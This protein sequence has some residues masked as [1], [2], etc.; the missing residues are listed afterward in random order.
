[1][2]SAYYDAPFSAKDKVSLTLILNDRNDYDRTSGL[3]LQTSPTSTHS[4]Y[5]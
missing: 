1:M 3:E 4:E 2:G 5:M